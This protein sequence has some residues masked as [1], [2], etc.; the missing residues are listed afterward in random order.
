[1]MHCYSHK[2]MPNNLEMD[3]FTMYVYKTV[4]ENK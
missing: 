2:N 3:D 1:M 4:K